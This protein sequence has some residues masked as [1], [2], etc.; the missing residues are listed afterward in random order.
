MKK[1]LHLINPLSVFVV[2]CFFMVIYLL[3]ATT[4]FDTARVRPV[5]NEAI[6]LVISVFA[7]PALAILVVVNMY[8]KSREMKMYVQ[9]GLGML[10]ISCVLMMY[11]SR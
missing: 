9:W 1:Y 10:F 11:F 2:F 6:A 4:P 5:S 3:L 7:V 8:I